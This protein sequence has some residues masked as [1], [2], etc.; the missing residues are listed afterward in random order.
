[1]IPLDKIFAVL[2]DMDG[3]LADT[4]EYHYQ[5]MVSTLASFRIEFSRENYLQT[6][7][8]NIQNVLTVTLGEPPTKKFVQEIL[9]AHGMAFCNLIKGELQLLPGVLEA[10]SYFKAR[11]IPQAIASSSADFLIQATIDEIRVKDFF[12]VVIS[13]AH[14]P[15]KPN[16]DIFLQAADALQIPA[17][18]CLVIEDSPAG[19]RGANSAGM[20]S[21]AVTNTHPHSEL[22]MAD[23]VVNSLQDLFSPSMEIQQ[24]HK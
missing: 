5:A 18:A 17:K 9:L 2:W 4:G 23:G 10:L 24:F 22:Q 7:G 14:L 3:V 6:F 12:K 21:L 11:G 20:F 15:P 1:M 13:G 19:I 16:P 8:T